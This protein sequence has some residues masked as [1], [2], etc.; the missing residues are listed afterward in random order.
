MTV[1]GK[2][3]GTFVDAIHAMP[4]GMHMSADCRFA[5]SR[6]SNMNKSDKDARMLQ[7]ATGARYMTSLARVRALRALA[8]FPDGSAKMAIGSFMNRV[9]ALPDL[10]DGQTRCVTCLHDLTPTRRCTCC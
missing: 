2:Y 8:P 3:V 6:K 5:R 10:I 9:E 4:D 1:G 7:N